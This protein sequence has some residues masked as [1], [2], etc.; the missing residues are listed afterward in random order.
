MVRISLF[1]AVRHGFSRNQFESLRRGIGN[2][3]PAV[4]NAASP[5]F[6]LAGKLCAAKN[7]CGIE[8]RN[9]L[10]RHLYK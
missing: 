3:Q 1:Q 7:T 8:P 9:P 6:G 10:Q 4:T 2:D 5:F